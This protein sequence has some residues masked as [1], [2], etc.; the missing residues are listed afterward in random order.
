[1]LIPLRFLAFFAIAAGFMGTPV[2]PWFKTFLE[3]GV[4]EWHLGAM[5]HGSTLFLALG[6][7]VIV[8][9]G[10]ATGWWYYSSLVFD[11]LRDPDPLEKKLPSGWFNVLK[12]KF[13]LDEFYEVTVIQ[14]SKNLATG[15]T[16]LEKNIMIPMMD[17]ISFISKSVSWIGR[18]WDEY[19]INAGFDR[20]C[21]GIQNQSNR[22]SKAHIGRVQFYLQVVVLGFVLLAVFWIWGG[23]Q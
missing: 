1:M 11:P 3:G 6:S 23:G 20:A 9:F 21:K 13:F 2:F 18:L 15:C 22:V 5:F 19:I 7:S 14:W 17:A 4:T 12:G 10:I 16:W 8:L